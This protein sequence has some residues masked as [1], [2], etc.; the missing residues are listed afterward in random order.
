LRAWPAVPL[1]GSRRIDLVNPLGSD[2]RLAGPGP[3]AGFN[4]TG[5]LHRRL[6]TPLM[7]RKWQAVVGP[8]GGSVRSAAYVAVRYHAPFAV[9]SLDETIEGGSFCI[10]KDTRVVGRIHSSQVARAHV[11]FWFFSIPKRP[12]RRHSQRKHGCKCECTTKYIP[13]THHG[14]SPTG[15]GECP[16]PLGDP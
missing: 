9:R 7:R 4:C 14:E 3:D 1:A 6:G 16:L 12:G 8:A 10:A 2:R 5:P 11:T 13:Q 15:S